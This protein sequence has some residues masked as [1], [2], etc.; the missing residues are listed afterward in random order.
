MQTI[1][2]VELELGK[3]TLMP[4]KTIHSKKAKNEF[5]YRCGCTGVIEKHRIENM[6]PLIDESIEIIREA[7]MTKN[8]FLT[9]M[10]ENYNKKYIPKMLEHMKPANYSS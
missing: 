4:V 1:E 5:A 6:N 8:I 7:R 2:G 3:C 10:E 9:C